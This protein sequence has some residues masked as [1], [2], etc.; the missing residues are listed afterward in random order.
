M[1]RNSL[2]LFLCLVILPLASFAKADT[3]WIEVKSQH[4]RVVTDAGEKNGRQIAERFEQMRAAFG[5]I[6]GRKTLNEP[7]PL[8]IIAFRNTKGI[9]LYSPLFQGKVVELAGFFIPGQDEDFVAIDLTHDDSWETVEHEYAHDLLNANYMAT[10]PWFDEGFAEF[11]SSLKLSNGVAELGAPIAEAPALLQGRKLGLQELF[12]V[13]HHSETYNKSGQRRD[14]FYVESWLVVHYLFDTDLAA[15]ASR[16]FALR[17][18]QQMPVPEAV[19]QAF[20][21]T[22]PQMEKAVLDYLHANKVGARYFNLK[23]QAISTD[24]T[25][26]T[27]DPLEAR[28]QLADLHLHSPD[29]QAAAVKEFEAILAENPNLADA[30]RGLGYAYLRQQNFP[31][32]T[33]HLQAA[34]KL[35]SRDPKVYYY[36]AMLL[37]QEDPAAMTSPELVANLR[38]AIELDPQYADAYAMLGVAL[39]NSRT[40]PAEAESN[41]ARAVTLSPR[42]DMIRLNYGLALLNQQQFDKGKQQLNL[43]L[44]SSDPM[45]AEQASQALQKA[46]DREKYEQSKSNTIEIAQEQPAVTRQPLPPVD[47]QPKAAAPEAP[48]QHLKTGYLKGTLVSVDCASPPVAVL[49]V[50]SGNKVWKMMVADTEHVV[51][52]GADTFS[53]SWTQKKVAFNYTLSAPNEGKVISLEIQ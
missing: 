34:A 33:E 44:H 28:A 3:S 10:A 14:M 46:S 6:F 21:M 29:Y 37:Q 38:H 43:V 9:R 35:G 32:A 1:R 31:K 45:V 8:T 11:F 50:S 42:N 39:M 23:D 22:V 2:R 7:V 49:T 20:G 52:I 24:V 53:C 4:F 36:T 13:E 47:S 41:L 17:N 26:R 25:V 40:S 5:L 18:N 16:Y 12:E 27:L 48:A 30:Q 15:K 51:V 19:Q